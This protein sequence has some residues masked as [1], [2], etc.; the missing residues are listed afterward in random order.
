MPPKLTLKTA[1]RY[2]K[3][4]DSLRLYKNIYDS[5]LFFFLSIIVSLS[6]EHAF[7]LILWRRYFLSFFEAG[8]F[9]CPPILRLAKVG[10][11]IGRLYLDSGRSQRGL[12]AGL[13]SRGLR[14]DHSCG[15]DAQRLL[16]AASTPNATCDPKKYLR[17]QVARASRYRWALQP[18]SLL[19]TN[20]AGRLTRV[21]STQ[22]TEFLQ[23]K[24][25]RPVHTIKRVRAG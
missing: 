24:R 3:C 19:G 4:N 22:K 21:A 23:L 6:I 1:A 14:P 18:I 10:C 8:T 15:V 9:C 2:C 16:L 20:P 5:Y 25:R 11:F 12:L 17:P 13:R 7:G